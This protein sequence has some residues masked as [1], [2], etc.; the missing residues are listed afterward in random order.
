VQDGW[1]LKLG[2]LGIG[3]QIG[4]GSI[5]AV[6]KG[7][8]IV[9]GKNVAVKVSKPPDPSHLRLRETGRETGVAR[10]DA[11]VRGVCLW[12]QAIR[13]D[14]AERTQKEQ[15]RALSDLVCEIDQ[16]SKMGKHPNIIGFFGAS[17]DEDHPAD[18]LIVLECMGGGCLQ[19]VLA[20]KSKNGKPWR[21]PKA[22]S[23]SWCTPDPCSR[24]TLETQYRGTSLIRNR[25]TLGPCSGT[26]PRAL[27]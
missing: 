20:D 12:E 5:G 7:T 21:P 23:F 15:T 13:E 8:H 19:G 17:V 24:S 4:L 14:L 11:D 25:P 16:L 6:F 22:T 10:W 26:M 2:E 18:T 1:I 9:S 3:R 27:W